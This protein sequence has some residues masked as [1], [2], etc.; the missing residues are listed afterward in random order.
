MRAG[1]SAAGTSS[2][3]GC[4]SPAAARRSRRSGGRSAA[5]A[6]SRC[7][8]FFA[9][10]VAAAAYW[11]ADRVVLGMVGARELPLGEAPAAARDRRVAGGCAP[12]VPKPR[13]YLLPDGYPRAL[14]AGRGPRG[15][16]HRGQ[17][18]AA[19][20]RPA[21]GAR[22]R[23]RPRARAHPQPRR[24]RPDRGRDRRRRARRDSAASAAGSSARC[25]SCSRRSPRRSSICCSRR[26]GS[27]RPTAS[28]P[29]LCDSPHGL[30]DAL[31]RL[32]QTSGA[33]RVPREPGDGA[34]VHAQPVRGGRAGG[35]LRDAPAG[36][37]AS[38]PA[39]A[40]DP[41]WR[42]KLRAA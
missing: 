2:R 6:W 21:G 10:L 19:R 39:A 5:T 37:G 38:P 16:A 7:F 24:P 29:Q 8:V 25:C 22:G 26:S 4:S 32:D 13:L 36:R 30:A 15:G 3:P 11:Y 12:R 31:L 40:L 34:A 1:S 41:D 35:A 23:D 27:S 18:R 33:R 17:P 9:L 20:G 42:E 28:Q 14:A